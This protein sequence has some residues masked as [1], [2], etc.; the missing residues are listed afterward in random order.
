MLCNNPLVHCKDLSLDSSQAGST[1]RATKLRIL[2]KR[3]RVESGVS[4]QM[5]RKQDAN[6]VLRKDTN[7]CG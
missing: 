6:A 2:G 3:K 1:E 7:P 5:Q 4:R